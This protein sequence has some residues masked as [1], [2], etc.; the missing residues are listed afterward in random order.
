[1]SPADLDTV[2]AISRIVHPTLPEDRSVFANRLDI[3]PPGMRVLDL[4]GVAS[5]Y[6]VAHP[7]R[8]AEPLPLDFLLERLPEEAD[9]FYL[10]DLALLPE[11][12]GRGFADAIVSEIIDQAAGLGLPAISLIAVSG[13]A[14]FW[15]RFGFRRTAIQPDKLLGYGEDARFLTL[16]VRAEPS[17]S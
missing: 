2:H 8:R 1:M 14:P 9:S 15:E 10:H 6:C 7:W 4:D 3:Y 12:R 5:G 16:A 11:A 17:S 13:S